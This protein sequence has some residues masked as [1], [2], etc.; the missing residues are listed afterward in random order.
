ML[1][2]GP[3]K[4][5]AEGL[6]AEPNAVAES[7]EKAMLKIKRDQLLAFE[8]KAQRSFEDEMVSHLRGF[9]PG[10]C[11]E[12]DDE[13]LRAAVRDG[14]VRADG[15]GFT[16]RGPLRL[17]LECM[18]MFGAHFDTD[19]QYPA[20]AARLRAKGEQ[21]FRAQ[22]IY[23]EIVEYQAVVLGKGGVNLRK[24]LTALLALARSGGARVDDE[25]ASMLSALTSSFPE[26]AA[27]VGR[28][29]LRELIRRG[30]AGASGYGLQGARPET[31]LV[32]AM[33]ALGHGVARDWSYPTVQQALA[34]VSVR[35]TSASAAR[36]EST[37][38]SLVARTLADI[39]KGAQR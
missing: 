28:D 31:A 13:Q 22:C 39:T 29:G 10:R 5:I 34:D 14:I 2:R 23:D 37:L 25:G 4:I 19:P 24:A 33:F 30:R 16:N 11:E 17:F 15:Y 27:Y 8:A 6:D 21:M 12:L 3:P 1:A 20:F 35:E 36:L 38:L 18:L 26:K 7:C 9:A 32:A